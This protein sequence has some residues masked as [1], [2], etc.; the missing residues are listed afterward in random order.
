M[1]KLR[2]ISYIVKEIVINSSAMNYELN[3]ISGNNLEFYGLDNI[4]GNYKEVPKTWYQLI[5]NNG[6]YIFKIV[7]PSMFN[8]SKIQVA[9]WYDNKS[10]TYTTEF[11]PDIK[12]LVDRY[13]ILVDTV[14]QLWEYTKRQMM[15]GD[16]MEMH[17]ILPKLN[18]EELWICKGDHYEAISLVDVN[19]ELRKLID[20]YAAIYKVQLEQKTNEQKDILNRY[21]IEQKNILEQYKT[22]KV[23]EL[24]GKLLDLKSQLDNYRDVKKQE[25]LDYKNQL[26]IQ[27]YQQHVGQI[28][29]YVT[30]KINEAGQSISNKANQVLSS[31]E[32]PITEKVQLKIDALFQAKSPKYLSDI[33]T[34]ID[35]YLSSELSRVSQILEGKVDQY[36]S[37]KDQMIK[38]KIEGIATTEINKA[39]AKAKEN[40]INEIESAANQKVQDA[41]SNFSSQANT[42]TTQKLQIIGESVDRFIKDNVKSIIL[43]GVNNYMQSFNVSS[44]REN[45]KVKLIFTLKNFRKE[46]E[47]PDVEQLSGTQMFTK[48]ANEIDQRTDGY[49]LFKSK[50]G[51]NNMVLS[52][53]SNQDFDENFRA[54]LLEYDRNF[55]NN[56]RLLFFRKRLIGNREGINDLK[57]G[58]HEGFYS[59]W[60][61]WRPDLGYP[62]EGYNSG[63]LTVYNLGSYAIQEIKT[64]NNNKIFIRGFN[65]VKWSEWIEIG[66]QGESSNLR[67]KFN[68]NHSATFLSDN[69]GFWF[70]PETISGNTAI[71]SFYFGRGN[72]SSYADIYCGTLNA[73][74]RL[75]AQGEIISSGDITAFSDIRLKSN[76]QKIDN[77]LDKVMKINGY[78]YDMN[79]KRRTGV[80]AQEVEQVLPEVVQDREDGYK[81]V[82]YGNM[83]GLLVEA[84]KE[85][86]QEIEVLKNGI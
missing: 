58:Q 43:D 34:Q 40:V 28:D 48:I 15:V 24:Y 50:I 53:T 46:V 75:I 25:L 13:N 23:N 18:K 59:L 70:N 38:D 56:N 27:L 77:A 55:V 66:T 62:I 45:N 67:I 74:S 1:S 65:A 54:A 72:T 68:T 61:Y 44:S 76:I 83:I 19:A 32:Q 57:E 52:K 14:S 42:L 51:L 37:S 73:S 4:T 33:K 60:D 12:V 3:G 5:R 7:D 36:I 9:L 63:I 2:N 20:R 84:I 10:L 8:Y 41:V 49:D 80:I 21:T 69:T 81:T 78:T 22:D 71:T 26:Q 11:N 39:V 82:A 64:L 47:L 31:L 16:S 17:L 30:S 29:S 86:K 85:L 35:S 6:N 79:N